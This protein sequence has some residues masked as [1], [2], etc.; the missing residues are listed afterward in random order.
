MTRREK[1]LIQAARCAMSDLI[2]IWNDCG[3]G[4]S[5]KQTVVELYYS[6]DD[7]DEDVSDYQGTVEAIKNELKHDAD[8]DLLEHSHE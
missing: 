6:L 5:A 7:W 8:D 2:G 1:N 3:L 4:E